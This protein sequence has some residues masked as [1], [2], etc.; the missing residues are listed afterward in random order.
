MNTYLM[1]FLIILIGYL[2]S[3]I[4]IKGILLR[5]S[6]VLLGNVSVTLGNTSFRLGT[7]GHQLISGPLVGHFGH[8]GKILLHPPQN[9]MNVM[10]EFGLVLFFLGTC[11]DAVAISYAETYS[12]ALIAVV[13]GTQF[14][15]LFC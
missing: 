12:I 14:I 3:R 9:T 13:S 2:I 10:R 6:G 8:I 7:S 11:T 4:D 5:T 1:A 15:A